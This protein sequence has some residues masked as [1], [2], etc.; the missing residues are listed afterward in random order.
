[1]FKAL[2]ICRLG[3]SSGLFFLASAVAF[4]AGADHARAGSKMK[5]LM[6]LP[7][8]GYIDGNA[9][10]DTQG[11]YFVPWVDTTTGGVEVL[12][13]RPGKKSK[14]AIF[15]TSN[16]FNAIR[17]GSYS[18]TAPDGV[19]GVNVANCDEQAGA[20]DVVANVHFSGQSLFAQT[21]FV[22]A[23]S[24][25][26]LWTGIA[27]SSP[28][29]FF[30]SSSDGTSFNSV[31]EASFTD[32]WSIT[33][34]ALPAPPAY[35]RI[36]GAIS[37]TELVGMNDHGS[38]GTGE[39]FTATISGSSASYKALYPLNSKFGS[40]F[41]SVAPVS[42]GQYIGTTYQSGSDGVTVDVVQGTKKYTADKIGSNTG[43]FEYVSALTDGSQFWEVAG[44]D[45]FSNPAYAIHYVASDGTYKR[46][47]QATIAGNY[48]PLQIIANADGS[49]DGLVVDQNTGLYSLVNFSAGTQ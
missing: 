34:I 42:G 9:V 28:T 12:D 44:A 40:R 17:A 26:C 46:Q 4:A 48:Y 30:V 41:L 16:A 11:G 43:M 5:V 8:T 31:A 6:Q 25:N 36:V 49:A 1:M 15:A 29:L 32:H 27:T 20:Q 24:G 33:P 22:S 38:K 19:G 2:P 39:L 23:N 35:D 37:A 14:W 45:T 18:Y 10:S 7:N 13:V 3:Q 47:S 21:I